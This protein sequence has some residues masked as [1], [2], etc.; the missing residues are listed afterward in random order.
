MKITIIMII[1]VPEAYV[2]TVCP[3]DHARKARALRSNN[4]QHMQSNPQDDR[5]RMPLAARFSA[6][7]QCEASINGLRLTCR[8]RYHK[9]SFPTCS[10]RV[11]RRGESPLSSE[12]SKGHQKCCRQGVCSVPWDV[13]LAT[14]VAS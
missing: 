12:V 11:A 3:Q 13:R 8:V 9:V 4:K 2:E 10:Q 14:G 1:S 7:H 6:S 5:R